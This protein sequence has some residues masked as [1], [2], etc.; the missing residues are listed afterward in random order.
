M[1]I[2]AS[3]RQLSD[4]LTNF[5]NTMEKTADAASIIYQHEVLADRLQ[6]LEKDH[7]DMLTQNH[8]YVNSLSKVKLNSPEINKS[9]SC[10]Q[11]NHILLLP[12]SQ[13]NFPR[14]QLRKNS[15]FG[16]TILRFISRHQILTT[17]IPGYSQCSLTLVLKGS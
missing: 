16:K 2:A 7:S 9:N 3:M 5:Y 17:T 1:E 6:G 4:N 12:L 8:K 14:I 11:S 10:R 15:Q 13:N